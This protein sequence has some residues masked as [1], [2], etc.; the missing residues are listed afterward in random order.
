MRV[1]S[2]CE[3]HNYKK[4]VTNFIPVEFETLTE[5]AE[6]MVSNVAWS[7]IIFKEN[8]RHSKNF[9]K[10]RLVVIDVDNGLSLDC[11]L[12]SVKPFRHIIGT[13]KSHQKEKNGITCDRFRIVIPASDWC[14]NLELYKQTMKNYIAAF[15][16]DKSGHDGGRFFF[17]CSDIMSINEFGK[18]IS[19][20]TFVP[21]RHMTEINRQKGKI[22]VSVVEF[23]KNPKLV[24]NGSR[25]LTL[26]WCCAEMARCGFVLDERLL[27]R[28]LKTPLGQILIQVNKGK[29]SEVA[30]HVRN[31][32]DAGKKEQK[33]RK[34]CQY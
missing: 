22:P 8:Y 18:E 1:I 17:R 19:W 21:R 26:F 24:K 25:H 6:I 28:I 31:G 9:I 27:D 11:A 23:L 16:G 13:T 3:N 14:I 12:E 4:N 2:I 30:R 34:G 5:L 10:S 29:E 33:E 15:S 7:P 20:C 32:F